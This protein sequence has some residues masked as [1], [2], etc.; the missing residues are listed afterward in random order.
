MAVFAGAS[1]VLHVL[2]NALEQTS[3]CSNQL[4]NTES[5]TSQAWIGGI[6][7]LLKLGFFSFHDV[8]QACLIVDRDRAERVNGSGRAN[9][10]DHQ[11]L[12]P[13]WI[14]KKK[15]QTN[16]KSFAQA[17]DHF[18]KGAKPTSRVSALRGSPDH[19][20]RTR[21]TDCQPETSMRPS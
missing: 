14:Q 9:I 19:N 15:D 13:L 3:L 11:L 5:G 17:I 8:P 12:V 20:P 21:L 18:S 1:E 7:L 16:R 10:Y 6:S 4:A 2:F